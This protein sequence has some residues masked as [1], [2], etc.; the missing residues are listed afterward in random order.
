M[1]V[2]DSILK[3]S[4]INSLA[5]IV[6]MRG[7]QY[8]PDKKVLT[9]DREFPIPVRKPTHNELGMPEFVNL[10]GKNVGRLTVLGMAKSM[11]GKWVVRCSCG[12]YTTRHSRALKNP[13]NADDMCEHCRH[14][15]YLKKAER[16]RTTGKEKL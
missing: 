1:S 8:A 10:T 5:R 13:A 3:L 4:P 2:I 7:E 9:G 6:T 12:I 15:E 16:F 14:L 11:K